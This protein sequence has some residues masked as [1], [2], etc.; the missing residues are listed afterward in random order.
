[1]QWKRKRRWQRTCS[2]YLL[3]HHYRFIISVVLYCVHMRTLLF[4]IGLQMQKNEHIQKTLCN[5][6]TWIWNIWFDFNTAWKIAVL[7]NLPSISSN[8]NS[9]SERMHE[10]VPANCEWNKKKCE[11]EREKKMIF[12]FIFLPFHHVRE[13]IANRQPQEQE[14]L[15][16]LNDSLVLPSK[17]E[18][19]R[20]PFGYLHWNDRKKRC[21]NFGN[22]FVLFGFFFVVS[23]KISNFVTWHLKKGKIHSEKEIKFKKTTE[24]TNSFKNYE[25]PKKTN[26]LFH[27]YVVLLLSSSFVSDSLTFRLVFLSSIVFNL[28]QITLYSPRLRKKLMLISNSHV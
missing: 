20:C 1:M 3:W 8:P 27:F 21:E 2:G 9:P 23:K 7:L 17:L 24:N 10:L 25:I 26:K 14:I 13:H 15:I 12:G 6:T 11:K 18:W 22:Y 16:L 5:R 19:R 4:L 28:K